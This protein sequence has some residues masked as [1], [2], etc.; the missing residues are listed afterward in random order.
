MPSGGFFNKDAFMLDTNHAILSKEEEL[1]LAKKM[2]AGCK[3]SKDKL[4]LHNIRLV[5]KIAHGFITPVDHD[6]LVSVGIEALIRSLDSY[7]PDKGFRVTTYVYRLIY[8]EIARSISK[9]P[10]YSQEVEY[11]EVIENTGDS[12]EFVEPNIDAQR[13]IKEC[14]DKA[15]LTR[16]ERY[17]VLAMAQGNMNPRQIGEGLCLSRERV[18]QIHRKVIRQLRNEAS[19]DP[20]WSELFVA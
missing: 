14:F 7:D 4:V 16:R 6:L 17:I 12:T 9:A 19:W 13:Y 8:W 20:R 11:D 2:K 10:R 1:E 18:A 15:D 3:K 5:H